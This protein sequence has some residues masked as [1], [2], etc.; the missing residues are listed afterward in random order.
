[1]LATD[2]EVL[3]ESAAV[4]LAERYWALTGSASRLATE[5]DDTFLVDAGT[6]GSY[7]L[8]VSNASESA[9]EIDFQC[10]L[11]AH[12]ADSAVGELVPRLVSSVDGQTL[13]PVDGSDGQRLA[14]VM[15]FMPGTPLDRC[16]SSASQRECIG[17]VLAMLRH[18]TRSFV[19]P[20]DQRLLPW[21]VVTLPALEPLLDVI[22][23]SAQRDLLARGLTR[24]NEV[25][26]PVLP[27]LRTQVLHNDFSK[28]NLIV[29]HDSPR[30]VTGVLDFGDSVKAPIAVDVSTALLNQLPSDLA[31]HPQDDIF[32]AGYDLLRGY[33]RYADLTDLELEIVPHLAMGRTITRALITNYRAALIPGNVDYILRNTEQG[34]AQLDWFLEREPAEISALFER[35][36]IIEEK[37]GNRRRRSWPDADEQRLRPRHGQQSGR[38]DSRPRRA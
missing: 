33:L 11:M 26:A 14:R 29:D 20:A 32:M 21:N 34:W 22:E 13:V 25:V 37:R 10:A 8:K 18:A 5:K 12:V 30:F 9:A 15:T 17:E 16:D 24:F 23:D 19:H 7:I 6:D 35:D 28:S 36:N 27:A 38:G 3:A 31:E 1:M 2:H 4:E